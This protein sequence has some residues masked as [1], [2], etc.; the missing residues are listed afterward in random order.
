MSALEQL[1]AELTR[2]AQAQVTSANQVAQLQQDNRD[3]TALLLAATGASVGAG[4]AQLPQ[5]AVTATATAAVAARPKS[6]IPHA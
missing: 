2:L 1:Q 4:A 3:I 5:Q 6:I